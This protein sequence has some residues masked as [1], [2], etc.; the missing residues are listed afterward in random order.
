MEANN[1]TAVS[2]SELNNPIDDT[3]KKE[4]MGGLRNRL[5]CRFVSSTC[6]QMNRRK[7]LALAGTLALPALGRAASPQAGESEAGGLKVF[8]SLLD[9]TYVTT[10][11]LKIITGTK[12]KANPKGKKVKAGKPGPKPKA[13]KPGPKPKA[14]KKK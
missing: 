11:E 1:I 3:T 2:A 5:M 13:G 8:Q 10:E 4:E 12:M 6:F 9:L 7:T 14:K